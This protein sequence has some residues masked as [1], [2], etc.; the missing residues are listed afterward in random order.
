MEEEEEGYRL[1]GGRQGRLSWAAAGRK[2]GGNKLDQSRRQG[3]WGRCISSM[4]DLRLA[5]TSLPAIA[6]LSTTGGNRRDR[7]RERGE[8]RRKL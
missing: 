8:E 3:G 5:V 6:F 2:Q 7:E 4:H 1:K